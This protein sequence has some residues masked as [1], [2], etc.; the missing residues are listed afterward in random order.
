[1]LCYCVQQKNA[2]MSTHNL[3]RDERKFVGN[4]VVKPKPPGQHGNA[5]AS[6]WTYFGSLCD[7]DG[8]CIDEN[9]VYCKLCLD[10]QQGMGDKGHISK[11]VN[12]ATNT[13]TGNLNMHLSQ[14]HDI[15]SN[16]EEKNRKILGYMTKYSAASSV[17]G[18]TSKHELNRDMV[19]WFCRDLLPFDLVSQEGFKGFFTKNAPN[20]EL[21]SPSA[22][23]GTGL[24][25]VY[26]AVRTVVKSK[27]ADV[28]AIC[29]MF[30]GWTDRYRAR[31]YLGVRASFLNEWS[32]VVVTLGCHVIP[33]H[34]SQAIAEHVRIILKSYFAEPK[35]LYITTVHDG[36]ANMVKTSKLLQVKS[37]HHCAAHSL[38]LLLTTDS[39]STISEVSQLLQKC[40]DIVTALHSKTSVGR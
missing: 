36:A 27:L 9:R 29:L 17:T 26:Q 32:Y 1:M 33:I 15:L 35:K 23:L 3:T 38:H 7:A 8:I 40:R 13:S 19:T 14:R 30:D 16:S 6:A 18:A 25:D 11:V 12:F 22:L 4:L 2:N 20:L 31:P 37:Y 39:I 5:K 10:M 28:K 24:E 34:T 21:P